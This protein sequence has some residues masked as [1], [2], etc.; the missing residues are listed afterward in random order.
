M[1]GSERTREVPIIFV[2]AAARDQHRLF[3][4][5]ESGGLDSAQ[6]VRDAFDPRKT[7]T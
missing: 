7:F 2:T 3:K 6:A 5:Y 1:R 4:G